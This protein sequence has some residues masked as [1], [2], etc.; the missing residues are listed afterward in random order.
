MAAVPGEGT[1]G[2]LPW[3]K[4]PCVLGPLLGWVYAHMV[5]VSDPGAHVQC[6]GKGVVPKYRNGSWRPIL[7]LSSSCPGLGT[8]L[9]L[10][11]PGGKRSGMPSLSSSSSHSSP[12]PSLS[13]SSWELLMMVGQLSVLSWCPSPSLQAQRQKEMVCQH[14]LLPLHGGQHGCLSSNALEAPPELK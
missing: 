7:P 3:P 12:N 10:S 2:P 9:Q 1:W 13:V 8:S 5:T 6:L 14:Q 11:G 4:G